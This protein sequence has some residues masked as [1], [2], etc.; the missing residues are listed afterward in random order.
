MN[1]IMIAI[2]Y[3]PKPKLD[4]PACALAAEPEIPP[5]GPPKPPPNDCDEAAAVDVNKH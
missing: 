5:K 3:L 1:W 2:N 4:E